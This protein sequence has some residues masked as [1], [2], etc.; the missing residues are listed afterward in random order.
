MAQTTA[1]VDALKQVLKEQS[2]TYRQVAEHLD[3]SLASVKRLFSEKQ[4]SLKRLDA[5]CEYAGIEI[6]DLARRVEQQR[7][8]S[9]LSLEQEQQLVEDEK[10]LIIAVSALN[11]W[12]F[13]DIIRAYDFSEAEMI[14]NLAQ[15]DRMKMIDLLPGNRIKP[16]ITTDFQWQK[17]GPIQRFFET[18][19]QQDFFQSRFNGAGEIRLF[20]TGMLTPASNRIMQQKMER[21]AMDFRRLHQEDLAQPLADR[22][23]TSLVLAM[24]PW[25]LE[26]FLRH[27]RPGTKKVFPG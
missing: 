3:M 15:L 5:V 21:L 17:N 18:Q 10:L 14:Q 9:Q 13:D 16:L 1:L 7:R 12:S 4:F 11:R 23:G 22:Y 6:S 25:E 26:F 27:R 19:V 2:I 20:V 8:I 24:R